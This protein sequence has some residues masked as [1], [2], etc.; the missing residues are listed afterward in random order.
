MPVEKSAGAIIFYRNGEGEIEYLLIQ[1]SRGTQ[2]YGFP[3]GLIEK[4]EGLVEA[5]LREAAEES[6]LKNLT[7]VREFKETAR[8]FYK[9]KFD[10]QFK[11]GFKPGDTVMKFVTYF[12]VESKDKKV[13]LSFEHEAYEWL[14]FGEAVDKLKKHKPTQLILKKADEFLHAKS[15]KSV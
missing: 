6:G 4:G 11:R 3:K 2:N 10:Y 9:A 5:A 12:L 8:Y 1:S 15:G 14:A 13:K 7:L